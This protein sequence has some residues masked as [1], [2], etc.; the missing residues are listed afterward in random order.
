MIFLRTK[1]YDFFKLEPKFRIFNCTI[2]YVEKLDKSLK[3]CFCKFFN[4]VFKKIQISWAVHGCLTNWRSNDSLTAQM[5][6][7]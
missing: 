3:I 2:F 1:F 7:N 6:A 5:R 4:V